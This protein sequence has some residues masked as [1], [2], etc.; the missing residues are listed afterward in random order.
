MKDESLTDAQRFPG[1]SERGW[2]TL[3]WMREHQNAPRFNHR[4]GDRLD[5]AARL[6]VR[7]FEE[8]LMAAREDWSTPG[9]PNWVEKFAQFCLR[10]VPIYR[11]SAKIAW[12]HFSDLP[13][14]SRED[15]ARAPWDFVP[16]CAALDDLIIY[17][18]TGTTG[19]PLD[20]LAH[21]EFSAKYLPILKMALAKLGI[22]IEQELENKDR[23][24]AMILVCAQKSTFTFATVTSVWNERGYIKINL[25]ASQ[26]REPNDCAKFLEACDPLILSG[27]PLS[28]S[29][30][31]KTTVALA[32]RALVS[33][34]MT[35]SNGLKTELENR[36]SC[37]VL[38][39][40]STNETGPLA[41][42]TSSGWEVLPHDIFVEV[43]RPDGA[44]CAAGERGEIAI[45]GG[46][47]CF[48]PLLRYRTGDFAVLENK[49]TPLG[50][51]QVLKDFEGRAPIIFRGANGKTI[52]NID[53]T[54]ALNS[55]ALAQWA[56]RQNA[57][58]S[59]QLRVRGSTSFEELERALRKL[60]G[61]SQ[62]VLIEELKPGAR[63]KV[64]SYSSDLNFQS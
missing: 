37:P 48:L 49:S 6:R 61:A 33:T 44:Q 63:D 20:I 12:T 5:A 59:L 11:S 22:S 57:D 26:W 45:T 51:Q 35:L 40:Y 23:R 54:Y 58:Y 29:Q 43:L 18:T 52:N 14:T 36:F 47:N 21:P 3:R 4:C 25:E 2:S 17:N 9:A 32:P 30:L 39:L 60:F 15:L 62:V 28:F 64:V 34:A 38:N 16:D 53:V 1:L 41:L 56:L 10:E 42:K 46:R 13:T 27:D 31:L 50:V 55:F 24:V 7:H 19:H 8:E